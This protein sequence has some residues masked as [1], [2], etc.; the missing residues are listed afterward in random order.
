MIAH[1]DE[2]IDPR[3]EEYLKET[4]LQ[5][6]WAYGCETPEEAAAKLRSIVFDKLQMRVPQNVSDHDFETLCISVNPV[7]LKN[8]PVNLDIETISRLYEQILQGE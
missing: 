4:L 5:I 8:H 7:R 2:C 1:T 6:A 3:G